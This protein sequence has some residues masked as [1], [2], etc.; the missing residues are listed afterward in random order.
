MYYKPPDKVV[1]SLLLTL[2]TSRLSTAAIEGAL[3]PAAGAEEF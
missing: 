3:F 2:K 1:N